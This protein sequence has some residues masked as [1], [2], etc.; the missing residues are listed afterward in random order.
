M[1]KRALYVAPSLRQLALGLDSNFLTSGTG[2]DANP[3]T[4]NWVSPYDEFDY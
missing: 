1:N 4:G 3:G 2:E